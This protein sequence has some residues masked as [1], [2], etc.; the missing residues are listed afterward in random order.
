MVLSGVFCRVKTNATG[1]VSVQVRVE[2][3]GANVLVKTIGS[4]P[5]LGEVEQWKQLAS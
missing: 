1:S 5:D 4:S 2:R 3:N